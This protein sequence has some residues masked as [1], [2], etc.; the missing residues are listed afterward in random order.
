MP[1]ATATLS[2]RPHAAA[3]D[4]VSV[5]V[6]RRDLLKYQLG[7]LPLESLLLDLCEL[8][9][10]LPS[11]AEKSLLSM[12]SKEK[13]LAHLL[14]M[15]MHGKREPDAPRTVSSCERLAYRVPWVI[16]VLIK[17]GD[18]AY[19]N[20]IALHA[21]LLR[22]YS[23]FFCAKRADESNEVVVSL[24]TRTLISLF[25][26]HPEKVC[27]TLCPMLTDAQRASIETCDEAFAAALT[28]HIH[29]YF[30]YRLLPK[31][32]RERSR[33]SRKLYAFEPPLKRGIVHLFHCGVLEQLHAQFRRALIKLYGT[34]IVDEKEASK[35]AVAQEALIVDRQ[36]NL[37]SEL[38]DNEATTREVNRMENAVK[39]LREIQ[40]RILLTSLPAP[41]EQSSLPLQVAYRT[42]LPALNIFA[43][44]APFV[45]ML[46]LGLRTSRWCVAGAPMPLVDVLLCLTRLYRL[47]EDDADVDHL[48]ADA[49][50]YK[51]D[52][53]PLETALA[54]RA[55]ALAD[56]LKQSNG[57]SGREC[58]TLGLLRCTVAEALEVLMRKGG[59]ELSRAL[60]DVR[61][62]WI[63]MDL[64]FEYPRHSLLH[65]IVTRSL[66]KA[67]EQSAQSLQA[68]AIAR[69]Y[70]MPE[71]K[72]AQLLLDELRNLHDPAQGL[73]AAL[74][75]LRQLVGESALP[76]PRLLRES[77]GGT[78]APAYGYIRRV[79]LAL[80]AAMED[81]AVR[82]ALGD[83]VDSEL[84]A[85]VRSS[86]E[87]LSQDRSGANT[88]T[89][90]TRVKTALRRQKKLEMIST[91]L[92]D[93]GDHLYYMKMIAEQQKQKDNPR[94]TL[95]EF[96]GLGAHESSALE[97]TQ[98]PKLDP[99]S[100]L[101]GAAPL[102]EA[103][104][105]FDG[106]A[107]L[108]DKGNESRDKQSDEARLERH[109]QKLSL[110]E[111]ADRL[112]R[113]AEIKSEN[114]SEQQR[115]SRVGLPTSISFDADNNIIGLLPHFAVGASRGKHSRNPSKDT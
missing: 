64:L 35:E 87:L 34:V 88:D 26:E 27:A 1:D 105:T 31:M 37:R 91:P 42:A 114:L 76:Q 93:D 52:R 90:L 16:S 2:A 40:I 86:V 22:K 103:E 20:G 70:L 17:D 59:P 112:L 15:L 48:I 61:L 99:V 51:H 80:G 84:M 55:G 77:F 39:A 69:C 53:A 29:V 97:K 100:D 102:S 104:K 66:E 5:A 83:V 47:F 56:L 110:S 94:F 62:P 44:P 109:D 9:E 49:S 73:A 72:L 54:E 78:I 30:V 32:V 58:A 111:I 10:V 12:L 23:E 50:L 57:E 3:T 28:N 115:R 81:E 79:A 107:R 45:A 41:S 36:G 98:K 67:L 13:E 38:Y 43:N 25:K 4:Q 74:A 75:P 89:K 108:V 19:R 65:G 33:T 82:N 113:S 46:D 8:R 68:C 14:D 6:I 18:V 106:Y 71:K 60:V 101:A 11:D 7:R 24:V 63:L 85:A 92:E 21:P 96:L 95:F